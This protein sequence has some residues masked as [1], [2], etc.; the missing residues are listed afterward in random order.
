MSDEPGG[1]LYI[2]GN[3]VTQG[4]GRGI[5]IADPAAQDRLDRDSRTVALMVA[6]WTSVHI[7]EKQ[8][9]RAWDILLEARR[10]GKEQ[11]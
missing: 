2:R 9:K 11:E 3:T 1:L 7:Y 10:Q 5:T 6:G 4:D 8:V